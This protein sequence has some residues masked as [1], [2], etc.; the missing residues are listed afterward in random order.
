MLIE[1]VADKNPTTFAFDVPVDAKE[2]GVSSVALYSAGIW[3]TYHNI[4]RKYNNN[5]LHFKQNGQEASIEF[6]GGMYDIPRLE[7]SIQ[8]HEGQRRTKFRFSFKEDVA[9]NRCI[10]YTKSDC[11]VDFTKGELGK[12]LGF[13]KKEYSEIYQLSENVTNITNNTER[14]FV[15][16]DLVTDSYVSNYFGNVSSASVI[17]SFIPTQ[18]PGSLLAINPNPVKFL[19]L[20][21]Q[22]IDSFTISITNQKGELIPEEQLCA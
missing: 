5:I 15:S 19:P 6:E 17:Y 12:L 13:E 20:K 1:L 7:A 16:C 9:T 2:K 4:D 10:L 11:S 21:R 14:I 18:A 22:I 3:Y 8:Q